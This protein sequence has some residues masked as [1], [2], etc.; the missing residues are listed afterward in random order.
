MKLLNPSSHALPA[1]F[2]EA[3]SSFIGQYIWTLWYISLW[4]LYCCY[5]QSIASQYAHLWHLHE[6][7]LVPIFIQNSTFATKHR[8]TQ[9]RRQIVDV[10]KFV[11]FE[12]R[13]N[14]LC[15]CYMHKKWSIRRISKQL[16][17]IITQSSSNNANIAYFET[18]KKHCNFI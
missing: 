12:L 14:F 3:C 15:E 13:I 18:T 11:K 1:K 4:L 10:V 16:F 2:I 8:K 6:F 7:E 9:S 17:E 5:F